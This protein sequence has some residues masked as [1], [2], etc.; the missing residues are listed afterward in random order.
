L[1]WLDASGVESVAISLINSYAWSGH[2]E[3]LRT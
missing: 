2:E 1:A 3:Q